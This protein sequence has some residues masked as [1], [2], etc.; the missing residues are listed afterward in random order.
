MNTDGHGSKRPTLRE[1]ARKVESS[2]W[3]DEKLTLPSG[4]FV[5]LERMHIEDESGVSHTITL[6]FSGPERR[7]RLTVGAGSGRA[8]MRDLRRLIAG[9][10]GAF[11]LRPEKARPQS[12]AAGGTAQRTGGSGK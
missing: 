12:R 1:L 7:R 3:D 2:G 9:R 11:G 8:A 4:D 10:E 6:L 5:W